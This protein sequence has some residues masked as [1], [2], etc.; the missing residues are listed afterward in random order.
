MLV[1]FRPGRLWLMESSSTNSLSSTQWFFVIRPSRKYGTT[2]PKLVAPI[3][4]N[5]RKMSK[6]VTLDRAAATSSFSLPIVGIASFIAL[7]YGLLLHQKKGLVGTVIID[8]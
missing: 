7:D 4:R 5:W 8:R 1:A 2:P 6:T 3:M